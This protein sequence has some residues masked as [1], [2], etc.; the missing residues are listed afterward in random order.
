MHAGLEANRTRAELAEQQNV[1]LKAKLDE[2]MRAGKEQHRIAAD[3]ARF[4]EVV[5]QKATADC[6]QMQASVR[7]LAARMQSADYVALVNYLW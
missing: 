6:E 3:A 5:R 4:V 7:D 1:V 2:V